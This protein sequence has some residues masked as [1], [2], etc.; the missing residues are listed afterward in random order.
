MT[1]WTTYASLQYARGA[2]TCEKGMRANATVHSSSM[3]W[4]GILNA[5]MQ[6]DDPRPNDLYM[7]D[8]M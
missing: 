3:I 2:P 4:T 6:T 5:H 7:E 1:V 8:N